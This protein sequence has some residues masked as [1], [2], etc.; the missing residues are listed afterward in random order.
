ML[1]PQI[2][3]KEV[4][5]WPFYL[6]SGIVVI[7]FFKVLWVW[8]TSRWTNYKLPEGSPIIDISVI[9]WKNIVTSPIQRKKIIFLKSEQR[10]A[11]KTGHKVLK[12]LLISNRFYLDKK[13]KA[14]NNIHIFLNTVHQYTS[15]WP[16]WSL[17]K[18]NNKRELLGFHVKK[19]IRTSRNLFSKSR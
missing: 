9:S 2:H 8:T 16:F 11:V 6:I 15:K 1:V 3:S 17:G 7:K 14:G 10:V 19:D 18:R 5:Q 4:K 12:L 13:K